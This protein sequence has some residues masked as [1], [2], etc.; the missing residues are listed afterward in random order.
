MFRIS[1]Q[2]DIMPV[3]FSPRSS[4]MRVLAMMLPLC[5]IWVFVACVVSCSAH[6][7]EA[8]EIRADLAIESIDGSHDDDLCPV[9]EATSYTLPE[10]QSSIPQ[11]SDEVSSLFA[12]CVSPT[13]NALTLRTQS[14]IRLSAAR[15]PLERLCILRI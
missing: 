12:P 10:R 4:F 5:F 11:I 8:H 13:N 1:H 2:P 9:T 3:M 7:A 14:S 15:P 6:D